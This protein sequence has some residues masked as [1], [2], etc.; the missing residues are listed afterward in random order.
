VYEA[1]ADADGFA[2]LEHPAGEGADGVFFDVEDGVFGSTEYLHGA[3]LGEPVVVEAGKIARQPGHDHDFEVVFF[4]N[5]FPAVTVG[6]GVLEIGPGQEVFLLYSGFEDDAAEFCG[7]KGGAVSQRVDDVEERRTASVGGRRTASD[8]GRWR[9]FGTA[10][11]SVEWRRERRRTASDGGR[12]RPFGTL[13]ESVERRREGNGR[14]F[15]TWVEIVVW[16]C[17]SL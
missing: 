10:P 6:N 2:G 14:L 12:W 13:P 4:V 5:E 9:S 1:V 11:E 3:V 17:H 16:W 15:R 8:G 7:A